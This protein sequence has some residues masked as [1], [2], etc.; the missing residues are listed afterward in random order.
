[1]GWIWKR[2]GKSGTGASATSMTPGL[3]VSDSGC[4]MQPQRAEKLL[5]HDR[6]KALL[7]LIWEQTS[8]SRA[9]FQKLYLTPISR[10]AEL[11]QEFPA[12][13]THHHAYAGGMLDHGLESMYNG[14]RLRQSY[15]LPP[16]AAPEDQSRQAEAWSTGIAYG[17]LIHD[18][19]KAAVDIVVETA[20]G[21]IGSSPLR[22]EHL[23]GKT[24]IDRLGGSS[25]L[26]GEHGFAPFPIPTFVGSSPLR[27]EHGLFNLYPAC[28]VGSSPLRGEHGV[29]EVGG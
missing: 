29:A 16:G 24:Y 12:S 9:M 22:G 19:G 18:V 23:G 14:L 6:R 2:K 8:M 5:Q 20:D 28:Q 1:M 21:K 13:E 3:S 17:C 26:R 25:P 4:Y 15:L 27:G 7:D 10:F 11:V